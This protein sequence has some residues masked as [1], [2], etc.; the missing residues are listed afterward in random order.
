MARPKNQ[1]RKAQRTWRASEEVVTRVERLKEV[2]EK[3][4]GIGNLS[5]EQL[6]NYMLKDVCERYEAELPGK[7]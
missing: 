7:R 6:I 4:A 3:K 1:H 2:V 5:Q